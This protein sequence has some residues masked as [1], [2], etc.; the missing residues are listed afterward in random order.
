[1]AITYYCIPAD[2]SDND[3]TQEQRDRSNALGCMICKGDPT[4]K[5]TVYPSVVVISSN[6]DPVIF[7]DDQNQATLAEVQAAE[8]T[9][10]TAETNAVTNKEANLAS[11]HDKLVALGFTVDEVKALLGN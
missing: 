7:P 10:T 4:E 6:V 1:M 8:L 5:I 2:T 11:A 9:A 3:I